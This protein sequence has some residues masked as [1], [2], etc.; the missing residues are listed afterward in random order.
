MWAVLQAIVEP[1]ECV[2]FI[3]FSIT[4]SRCYKKIAHLRSP[5]LGMYCAFDDRSVQ[6]IARPL[7]RYLP[8]LDP[9]QQFKSF[10]F[11]LS[12]FVLRLLGRHVFGLHC[13]VIG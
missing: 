5:Y 4:V 3:D 11:G 1:N 7:H 12:L 8:D 13:L 2:V 10:V 9:P 6:L